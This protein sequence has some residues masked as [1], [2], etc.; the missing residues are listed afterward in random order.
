M[1]HRLPEA[2]IY[3]ERERGA[4]LRQPNHL[5]IDHAGRSLFHGAE[6]IGAA[7]LRLSDQTLSEELHSSDSETPPETRPIL[8]T[9]TV[10]PED[11]TR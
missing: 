6:T 10:G 8:G 2:Q 5:A 1:R 11:S 3:T 7:P 9:R 4:H